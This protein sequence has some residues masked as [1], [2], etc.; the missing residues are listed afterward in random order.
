MASKEVVAAGEGTAGQHE[1]TLRGLSALRVTVTSTS[2]R[3]L[4]TGL[5]FSAAVAEGEGLVPVALPPMPHVE[6]NPVDWDFERH[7]LPPPFRAPVRSSTRSDSI[8]G[9]SGSTPATYNERLQPFGRVCTI[10]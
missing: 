3:S 5:H 9:P 1:S 10:Y 6:A 8:H 4:L 7:I 2:L